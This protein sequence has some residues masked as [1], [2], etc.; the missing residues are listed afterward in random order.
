VLHVLIVMPVGVC[1]W[2][3][4]FAFGWQAFAFGWQVEQ[5]LAHWVM[6]D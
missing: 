4:I 2:V 6:V 1:Y 5:I 3:Q